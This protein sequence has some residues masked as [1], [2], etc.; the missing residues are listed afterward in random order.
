LFPATPGILQLHASAYRAPAQLPEGGVLVV[1]AGA[2]GSQIAE[3]LMR[4]G[5]RVYF[6]VGKHKRAPRRYRGHDH[7]WWWIETGMDV[8]P[9]ERR[10]TDRSPVVHTGA[11]G[12]R[13]MDFRDFARQGM[14]LLGRAEAAHDGVM[15]FAP[16]LP[17]NLAH[18]DA[19]YLAFMDFV[20]AH[21][22]RKG[23]SLP[24]DPDARVISPTPPGLEEPIRSLDLRAEGVTTVI[25][26][27]GYRLDFGWIDLPVLDA[28]GMPVHRLG[29]TSVPGLYFLGLPFLSKMSSSFLF[30]VGDDAERLAGLI[31]AG[32]AG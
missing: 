11:Y 27:T 28:R 13:T 17:A 23:L 8:T 16:D 15:M 24:E 14:V 3:E 12:G 10:P 7:I 5:R 22:Q 32:H 30:G 2:S 18:G 6:S 9:P 26:A 1:G 19:A 20:D 4:A 31:G 21:I 25:W 29:V